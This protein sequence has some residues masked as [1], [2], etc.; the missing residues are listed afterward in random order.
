MQI[1]GIDPAAAYTATELAAGIC[2]SVGTRG[3]DHHGN[4]YVL[5]KAGTGGVAPGEVGVIASNWTLTKISTSNDGPCQQLGV[6]RGTANVGDYVWAQ[7][8]GR[9]KV[10]GKASAAADVR[11]NTTATAGALDDDGSTGAFAVLGLTLATAV[12][13]GG[14]EAVNAVLNYPMTDTAAL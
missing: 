10:M 1:L 7:I 5:V 3:W 14:A 6:A 13:A 9:G 11:L 2:P 12:G 8:W 4:E